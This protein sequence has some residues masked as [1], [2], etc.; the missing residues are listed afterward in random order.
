MAGRA[1]GYSD[2]FK[3]N[4]HV[5][6]SDMDEEEDANETKPGFSIK[7]TTGSPM[8]SGAGD[9]LRKEALKRRLMKNKKK[10]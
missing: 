8:S 9:K 3:N 1:K 4:S 10:V 2:Y 6:G 5:P 7:I